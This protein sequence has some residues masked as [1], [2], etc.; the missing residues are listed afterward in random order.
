MLQILFRRSNY[1]YNPRHTHTRINKTA[2]P[3]SH[4][5]FIFFF[6]N[7]TSHTIFLYTPVVV[8]VTS[9][10]QR[11]HMYLKTNKGRRQEVFFSSS[12]LPFCTFSKLLVRMYVHF[13]ILKQT[14][15]I[16]EKTKNTQTLKLRCPTITSTHH[17]PQSNA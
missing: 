9:L 10:L 16:C 3:F 1:V 15:L 12:F 17:T 6:L 7:K 4:S 2:F 5:F 8:V 11:K 14:I 13:H